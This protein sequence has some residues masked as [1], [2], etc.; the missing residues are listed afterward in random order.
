MATLDLLKEIA[1]AARIVPLG[2][3]KPD[4]GIPLSFGLTPAFP[5]SL[6]TVQAGDLSAIWFT[7]DVRFADALGA[8]A[9]TGL[10]AY[11]TD[12]SRVIGG[13]PVID[14][15]LSTDLPLPAAL[16]SVLKL[17]SLTNSVTSP[18]TPPAN[19]LAAGTPGVLGQLIGVVPIPVKVPVTVTVTWSVKNKKTGAPATPGTDIVAPKGLTGTVLDLV[20]LA[21]FQDLVPGFSPLVPFEIGGTIEVKA[22]G[23]TS[24]PIPLPPIALDIPA[25]LGIPTLV[26]LFR[27]GNYAADDGGPGSVLLA[28]PQN[29]VLQKADELAPVLDTLRDTI[30]RLQSF[31]A[32]AVSGNFAT[33]LLGL[34]TLVDALNG[35]PKFQLVVGD[36]GHLE[37]VIF[38]ESGWRIF[39]PRL[40]GS[41]N[42]EDITSSVIVIGVPGHGVKLWGDRDFRE[43]LDHKFSLELSVGAGMWASIRDFR[44]VTE[45]GDMVVSPPIGAPRI[46]TVVKLNNPGHLELNDRISSLQ[47]I[48]LP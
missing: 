27:H 42:A 6:D 31:Q 16:N 4:V 34:G 5:T 35:Q 38:A 25:V 23:Q 24:G 3:A 7:K 19:D 43:D 37:R 22:L 18:P 47:F 28:V 20:F 26:A 45:V 29:A 39:P 33:F 14:P 40:G 17:P 48:T 15:G 32:N 44:F 30:K 10:P 36:N 1:N 11:L 9:G 2:A 12:S 46:G 8:P 21:T 41:D 13:Q